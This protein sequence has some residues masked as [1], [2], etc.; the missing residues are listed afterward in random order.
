MRKIAYNINL[1]RPSAEQILLQPSADAAAT[2]TDYVAI[3]GF[4][5]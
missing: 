4:R 1:R 2:A 3:S 5:S